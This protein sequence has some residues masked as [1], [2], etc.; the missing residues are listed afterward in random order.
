M[1]KLIIHESLGNN[2]AVECPDIVIVADSVDAP[3]QP[4]Q[5]FP[6]QAHVLHSQYKVW[7]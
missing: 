5:S 7:F 6:Q 2:A 4:V 3:P 1:T